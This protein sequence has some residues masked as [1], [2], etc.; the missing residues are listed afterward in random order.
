MSK[1]VVNKRVSDIAQRIRFM[2]KQ[3]G[4]YVLEIGQL[5]DEVKESL[6]YKPWVA[7]VKAEFGWSHEQGL[8][9]VRV[10]T[11][12]GNSQIVSGD[13]DV[14]ALYIL[15]APSTPPEARD[16]AVKR[17]EAGDK[18]SH[19]EAKKIVAEAKEPEVVVGTIG[20]PKKDERAALLRQVVRLLKQVKK[21]SE[22][23]TVIHSELSL[24][25]SR[26][27]SVVDEIEKENT[28]QAS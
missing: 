12:F 2:A 4:E 19:K 23:G 17:A 3:T 1:V 11:Q 5:L 15:S 27:R 8:R 22:K 18:I 14:S 6:G 21:D 9:F 28:Q 10:H 7:W 20:V 16:E 13:I 24:T 25:I 26:L